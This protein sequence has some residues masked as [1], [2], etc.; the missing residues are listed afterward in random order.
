M[1]YGTFR[2][3][4]NP[5]FQL[6]DTI[7]KNNGLGKRDRPAPFAEGGGDEA[8]RVTEEALPPEGGQQGKEIVLLGQRRGEGRGHAL[9]GQSQP[10]PPVG[11]E[12]QGRL[13]P[14]AEAA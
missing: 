7:L 11:G 3:L 1:L 5:A 14:R 8:G 10:L 12:E 2:I 13:L 9:L 4:V 6:A